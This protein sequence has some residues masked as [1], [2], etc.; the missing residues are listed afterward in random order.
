MR[1]SVALALSLSLFTFACKKEEKGKGSGTS[2]SPSSSS[3]TSP[4]AGNPTDSSSDASPGSSSAANPTVLPQSCKIAVDCQQ[5]LPDFGKATGFKNSSNASK[6]SASIKGGVHR[7]RDAMI[8][9]GQDPFLIVKFAYSLSENDVLGEEVDIY[10]SKGCGGGWSK[11]GTEITSENGATRSMDGVEDKGGYIMTT[12]SKLGVANL[13]VG[14]HRFV[15]VLKAN[16]DWTELYVEVLPKTN[17]VIVTDID[18]T[19]TGFE[20]A[21]A[22]EIIGIKPES[23]VGAADMI[24]S[25]YH[26][27]Y[28][29]FYLT[30][31]PAFL[32]SNTREWLNSRGFPPGTIHTTTLKAGAT[33]EAAA[34]FKVTEL[35]LLKKNTGVVP[36]YAFGNKPSDV[37]AFATSGIAA[38]NSYF[39]KIEGDT[40]GAKV[41]TDYRTLV[42]MAQAAPSLCP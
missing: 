9:E 21:A 25:F 8:N 6:A 24:R 41:N 4:V 36:S 42:P 37:K 14:R 3:S 5:A 39:Y 38:E 31:R 10:L 27:G 40:T 33:G 23:H 13:A 35:A 17:S 32:M 20:E 29:I 1:L 26:R 15:F 7:G 16:N 19:L 2:A 18:G 11:I 12:A 22:T 34:A 28:N 30:A